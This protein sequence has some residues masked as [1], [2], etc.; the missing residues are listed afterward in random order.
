MANPGARPA[1]ADLKIV[2]LGAAGVGKMSIITRYCNN[3]L[4][5]QTAST[6]GAGFFTH[7]TEVNDVEM[8]IMIGDTAGEERP[9]SS[10]ARM[11]P[12]FRSISRRRR[13]SAK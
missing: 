6:I 8:T 10:A 2:V 5:E 3:T 13:R 12:Y 9:P 4:K 11:A 1:T 7:T